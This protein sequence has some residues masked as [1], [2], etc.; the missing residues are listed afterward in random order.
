MGES[1]GWQMPDSLG[2]GTL[3]LKKTQQMAG[4]GKC[5]QS[6]VSNKKKVIQH[7]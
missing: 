1:I 6:N 7:G 3:F 2:D 5:T 4:P